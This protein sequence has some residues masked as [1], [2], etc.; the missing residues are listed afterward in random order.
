M[1]L[2]QKELIIRSEQFALGQVFHS[3]PEQLTY[4]EIQELLRSH[5]QWQ[6]WN[7]K[8]EEEE[9]DCLEVTQ[10]NEGYSGEY[11]IEMLDSLQSSY[12]N[13]MQDLIEV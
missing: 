13:S 7:D 1:K 8:H 3:Y 9:D 6:T 2:T 12:F 10:E 11:L 4:E 5:E